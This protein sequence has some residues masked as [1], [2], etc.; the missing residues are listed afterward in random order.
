MRSSHS[1]AGTS[2]I[3]RSI[4]AS[5][6]ET[7]CTTADRPAA[8]SASMARMVEGH[9]MPVSRWP[10]NLCFVPSKAESA[11]ALAFL[12]SVSSPWTM[13]VAF[14]ASSMLAWITLKAPA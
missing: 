11:A 2:A 6:V 1:D 4:K 7:S 9:F 3:L 5:P 12:L 14:S 8:R 13:P 10:K